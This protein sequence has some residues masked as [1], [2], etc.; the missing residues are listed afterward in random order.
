MTIA[1]ANKVHVQYY[2][3]QQLPPIYYANMDFG[4]PLR[5]RDPNNARPANGRHFRRTADNL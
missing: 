5:K 1:L 4:H 2:D 3:A